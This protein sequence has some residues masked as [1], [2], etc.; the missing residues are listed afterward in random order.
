MYNA[1]PYIEDCLNS[2][3][4][5]TFGD[6]EVIIV[7]DGSNDGSAEIV[8]NFSD[9]RIVLIKSEHD[10]IKS[11]NIALD[12]ARG[13]YIARMDADDIMLPGRLKEEFEYLENHPKVAAVAG[14]RNLIGDMHEKGCDYGGTLDV[15][16]ENMLSG[17]TVVNSTSMIR[18]S[19][20]GRIGTGTGGILA[21]FVLRKITGGHMLSDGIAARLNAVASEILDNE[22]TDFPSTYYA[23]FW[24]NLQ[25]RGAE[26][27]PYMPKIGEWLMQ[28]QILPKNQ[29]Y[30]NAC[31]Y[32]GCIGAVAR[33][34][35]SEVFAK[36]YCQNE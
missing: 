10:F 28:A 15:T 8:E 30:W 27:E 33:L 17:N 26:A 36:L 19:D 22:K 9:N 14:Y 4:Q 5:Q 23:F 29:K 20:N 1:A 12:N 35:E 31:L 2:I 32:G 18:R 7:D 25:K 24:L 34:I 16:L 11:L 13:K 3:L 21:Y 6:F